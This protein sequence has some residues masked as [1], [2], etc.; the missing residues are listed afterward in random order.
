MKMTTFNR[1]VS[2]ELMAFA[3]I[4]LM[5]GN[6]SATDYSWS[7]AADGQVSSE[8]NWTPE[9]VPTSSDTVTFDKEGSYCVTETEDRSLGAVAVTNAAVTVDLIRMSIIL[10]SFI[11]GRTARRSYCR[12]SYH[13]MSRES[14]RSP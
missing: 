7:Q 1:K 14:R 13:G 5:A 9:G 3:L 4:M 2:V 8:S 12:H 11:W 10:R 6:L